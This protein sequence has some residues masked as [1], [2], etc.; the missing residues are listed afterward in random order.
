VKEKLRSGELAFSGD[1]WP[2]FLYKDYKADANDAWVGLFR[3]A[4]LITA[5]KFIFTSPSSVENETK[6]TRSGNARIHGMNEV[7]LS[8]IAYTATQV[9][10]IFRSSKYLNDKHTDSERFYHSVLD[11]FEDIEE[12]KEVLELK[13]W[14]DSQIFPGRRL[15]DTLPLKGTLAKIKARRKMI[16]ERTLASNNSL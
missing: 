16:R 7:S 2:N 3:S 6:A 13:A 10:S 14:W 15:V 9:L 4:I 1:V 12:Q 11:L 8:S 5:Y